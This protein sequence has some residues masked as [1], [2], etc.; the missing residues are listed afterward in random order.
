M[1]IFER[2]KKAN[3]FRRLWTL[4]QQNID[5]IQVGA[6]EPGSNPELDE[7]IKLRLAMEGFLLQGDSENV[8]FEQSQQM[9]MGIMGI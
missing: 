3:H 7:A 5:L 9:L 2:L 6:Y 4:Y 8:S 1:N